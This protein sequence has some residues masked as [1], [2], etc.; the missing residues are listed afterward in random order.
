MIN[1]NLTLNPTRL[2]EPARS[3]L[4]GENRASR[5]LVCAGLFA[6]LLCGHLALGGNLLINP[7]FEANSGNVVAAGWTYFMP[8]NGGTP[9]SFWCDT[10]WANAHTGNLYWKQWGIYWDATR[11]NVA[12][13]YQ[14]FNSAPGSTYTADG[15]FY[16]KN[17]LQQNDQ[18]GPNNKAWLEVSF[19]NASGQ[20][21]A[22]YKSDDFTTATGVSTWFDLQV[23]NV[24]NLGQPIPSGDT[25]SAYLYY[26][27]TGAVSQLVAP[28]GT[29]FIRYQFA[30]VQGG[31]WP[32]GGGSVY[33]DD[34]TLNQISGPVPPVIGAISPPNPSMFINPADGIH[35][36]ASSASG[37]TINNSGI[38]MTVNGADVSGALNISGSLSNKTVSYSGL[39]SNTAYTVSINVTDALSF[40]ASATTYFETTW[41]GTQPIV[42]LW[43]SEDWDYTNGMYINNPELCSAAGNPNCYFGKVGVQGVDEN[44]T[45]LDGDHLYRVDD[46]LA[47]TGSGDL[48]RPNLIAAN[49][50]DYKVG[51]FEGGEWANYTR[52][53]PAGTYWVIARLANGGGAG[54]LTLSQVSASGT[55]TLGTFNIINGRGWTAYDTYYLKDTNG[56]NA[57]VTLNGK[58]TLRA[59]TGGNVDM[60][61]FALVTPQFDLPVLSN[62]YPT[63]RRPFEPTNTLSFNATSTGSTIAASGVKV[64]LDGLD[65]S[66]RLNVSAPG[67]T[68]SVVYSGLAFNAPHTAVILVTN[69]LG[70]GIGVTNQFDTFTETNF[71]VEAEDFDYDGGAF[72]DDAPPNS[73]VGLYGFT[74]I[75]FSHT[76]ASGDAAAYRP[77]GG[78]GTQVAGDYLRHAFADVGYIDYNV[79]YFNDTDWGNYTRTYPAGK[80][81][82]YGRF[83][84]SGGY[85]MYLDKVISG[86]G[87]VNQVTQR[88][89]RWGAVGRDWQLYDW[90]PLTDEGLAAPTIVSLGGVSTLRIATTGNCNPNYFMLVP[91]SGISVSAE[92]SGA[93]IAIKIPTEAGTTYRV[94][95]RDD[96]TTGNWVLMTTIV[97]DGTVNTVTAPATGAKRF[98]RVVSP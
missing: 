73:Y 38:R 93:N 41:I 22:L 92:R 7:S 46:G 76:A 25:N 32:E 14:Q 96:L 66:S 59:T 27:V 20:V 82:V 16:T 34:A 26:A 83:A 51:W 84:G 61:F 63:G 70:H 67:S 60:G 56:N 47:T 81:L 17:D 55:N 86:T 64:L 74:N 52:D 6:F 8:P 65:V 48:M 4:P 80:F 31:G 75:D 77:Q 54:T 68:V 35:F 98:Y 1:L 94:F 58:A 89:G 49:R 11:T 37:T 13:I 15:W 71:M 29:A 57:T 72:K 78:L 43:E 28:P 88:L 23:T 50:L 19:R 33:F 44:N 2:Q 53:W 24:C 12:G 39:Q 30:M 36:T 3:G 10:A 69:A 87:T 97:G 18:M 90:V 95:Y 21:L 91:V 9:G 62:V 40:S 42:Y 5:K 45:Q 79:G 85:S